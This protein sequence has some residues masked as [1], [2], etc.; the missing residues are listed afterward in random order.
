[1]PLAL[2][3]YIFWQTAGPFV[4]ATFVLSGTS[5]II[6]TGTVSIDSVPLD[7]AGSLIALP[8]N[9]TSE[10]RRLREKC[11][12]AINHEYSSLIVVGRGGTESAPEE[13]QPDFGLDLPQASQTP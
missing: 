3:R 9:L 5:F 2:T 12:R 10:E 1:M 8:A 4:V 7:L 11:A 6:A 13:L